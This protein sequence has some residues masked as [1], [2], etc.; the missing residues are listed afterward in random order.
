ML[1]IALFLFII[2]F[3]I[4][5]LTYTLS[6]QN[7]NVKDYKYEK[8]EEELENIINQTIKKAQAEELKNLENLYRYKCYMLMKKERSA[9][10]FLLDDKI[11]LNV[12]IPFKTS[13]IYKLYIE[14][15]PLFDKYASD[16]CGIND[17]I[18]K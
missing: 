12:K 14:D 3:P 4:V 13:L 8:N 9:N 15:Y 6:I 16:V 7:L 5:K 10:G 2:L 17:F 11:M 1:L 18:G